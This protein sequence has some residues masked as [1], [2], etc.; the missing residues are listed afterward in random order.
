MVHNTV[1]AKGSSGS[2]LPALFLKET[3]STRPLPGRKRRRRGLCPPRSGARAEPDGEQSAGPNPRPSS[4]PDLQVS[5]HPGP[6]RA[7][8]TPG[9]TPAFCRSCGSLVEWFE[10]KFLRE[11]PWLPVCLEGSCHVGQSSWDYTS[12]VLTFYTFETLWSFYVKSF[13]VG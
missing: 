5:L 10:A 6:A 7:A 8:G 11:T 12:T 1:Q 13:A 3:D 4:G 2:S 9:D